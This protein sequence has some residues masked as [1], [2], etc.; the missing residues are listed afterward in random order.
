MAQYT[1]EGEN[2]SK[3][4]TKTYDRGQIVEYTNEEDFCHSWVIVHG[5]SLIQT[6]LLA[7]AYFMFLIYLFLGIA[8][9]S[10]LF[11]DSIEVITSQTKTITYTDLEGI[12]QKVQVSVWNPTVANLT[13]MALGSSAP[14]ILLSVIET[15]STLGSEPG[16]LGPSTIVGSAAFNLMVI[17][18]VT[19]ASIPTGTVKKI[20]DMGVFFITT[21]SSIFAYVWLYICLEVWSAGEIGI[22]EA[23]ITFSFFWILLISAFIADKIRQRSDDKKRKKLQQFNVEDFYHIINA[24][25]QNG[26][27]E[28]NGEALADEN[29]NKNHLELQKYLK[30]VF[31]KD[32]IEDIDP[33]EVKSMLKPKSVVSERLQYRKTLGN[34]ISGRQKVAVVKGEKNIEE[35]KSAEDMFQKHELNPKIGFRCLHYS[36]TESIGTLKVIIIKKDPED[37]I[38]VGVRTVDGTANAGVD[39]DKGDYEAIDELKDLPDG[40]RQVSVNVKIVDDEGCEPDEDFYVELYDLETNERLPGEDTRTTITILDDD[41]PGI[42]GFESRTLKVRAKDEKVRIKVLRLDGCDDDITVGYKTFIPDNLSNPA[43]PNIDYMPVEG[44]LNYETGETMQI[45][46]V[47]IMAKDE[48]DG[49]ER[50]DVFAVKIFDPKYANDE[51]QN[52]ENIEKPKLGKKHECYVEIVGDNE[53]I[54]KAKGIEEIIEQMRQND[55]V[56]WCG[57]FKQAC[58]LSPQLDENNKMVEVSGTEALLHFCTIGWKLLFSLIPPARYCKGWLSFCISL[59]FIGLVTAIVGEVATL[60]GC[61]IGL[62]NAATAITFVALGTSLPDTFASKQAAQQSPYADTAIGNVT[63]S[64]SVNIFLGLGIPWLI[65][66]IYH[67]IEGGTFKVNTEGLSFSVILFLCTSCTCIAVLMVRR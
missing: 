65:G 63:G 54:D 33:E 12:E 38:S 53:L 42:F 47:G 29:V 7:I 37:D 10:D 26:N 56:T 41:K 13:L 1:W 17:S 39:D 9:V 18:A 57:Q 34:M 28:S 23:A 16:E 14:E 60:F 25:Q 31:G 11:M 8:L 40:V 51:K 5:T 66:S 19:I 22:A 45:I 62:K 49:I 48:K 58:M 21:I 67:I 64:N 46:E 2:Y 50:D 43:Q 35:L 55:E 61:V 36:V 4:D 30:E 32:K 3:I 20:N 6:W 52:S 44:M 24:K 59:L 27:E 15:V